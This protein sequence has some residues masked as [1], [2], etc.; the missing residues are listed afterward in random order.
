[1]ARFKLPLTL[2]LAL[3]LVV[4]LVV[5]L[6]LWSSGLPREIALD[7]PRPGV[8]QVRVMAIPFTSTD[9]LILAV[10]GVVHASLA[11][12]VWKA[13]RTSVQP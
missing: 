13:W 6:R 9:W 3:F 12:L 4:D 10:V 5:G 11:F 1:M 7:S 8:E 2:A